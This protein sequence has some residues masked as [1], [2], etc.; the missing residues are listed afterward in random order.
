MTMSVDDLEKK[1]G[2]DFFVNLQGVLQSG[3]RDDGCAVL[4]VVHDG[5]VEGLL[6]TLLDIETLRSL[7]VF[8]VNTTKGGSNALNGLAEL[9]RVF[10]VDLDIENVDATIDLEEQSLTFHDG[11]AAHGANIAQTQY[12]RT[13]GDNSHEVALVCILIRI[14]GVLLDFQTG[15]GDARRIWV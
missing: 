4:V 2:V 9:L 5:N 11:L 6:Q 8:E 14:V 10:L 15:V 3:S 1:V 13:V 12:C 7:D